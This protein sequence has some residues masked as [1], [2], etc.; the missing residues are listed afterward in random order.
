MLYLTSGL[1]VRRAFI[2]SVIHI[3]DELVKDA[4]QGAVRDLETNA[5][6]SEVFANMNDWLKHAYVSEFTSIL[7]QVEKYGSG[8]KSDL[9]RLIKSSWQLRRDIATQS[10]KE[11]ET[12]L[13]FPSMLIFLGVM[14]MVAVGLIL[15][16]K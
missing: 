7:E 16:M 3:E 6:T 5:K 4:L 8:A 9:D 2:Q 15:Q 14:L 12:K 11:M 13:V 1:S 10:A